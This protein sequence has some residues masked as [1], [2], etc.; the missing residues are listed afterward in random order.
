M[1]R[2]RN[3]CCFLSRWTLRRPSSMRS[4]RIASCW[5]ASGTRSSRSPA[6]AS[7]CTRRPIRIPGSKRRAACRSWSPIS[8]AAGL[9]AGRV[10]SSALPPSTPA[11]RAS[12]TPITVISA[13]ARQVYRGLDIGTAKPDR[14]TLA[15]VPHR[16]LDL[17]TP[18]ESYSA[19]RFA[20]DAAAWIAEVRATGVARQIVVVGGTGLYVRAIADGLFREPPFDPAR[21]EQLRQ[22][23]ES[24]EA[25]DLAR[26]AG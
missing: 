10:D 18:G 25:G 9:A 12:L 17:V 1:A 24:L 5:R 7:W 21:R 6:E 16:G 8:L 26:W 4:R 19:G 23:S 13:D 22:W 14:A 20:R 15:R 11:A 2:R 3:V